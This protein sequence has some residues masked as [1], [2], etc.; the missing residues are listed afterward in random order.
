[1]VEHGIERFEHRAVRFARFRLRRGKPL[2][3]VVTEIVPVILRSAACCK[4]EAGKSPRPKFTGRL[5]CFTLGEVEAPAK[6]REEA[7]CGL[8]ARFRPRRA[9]YLPRSPAPK[10]RCSA[11]R[12]RRGFCPMH[13]REQ[14]AREEID[15][16]EKSRRKPHRETEGTA[17]R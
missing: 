8:G 11:R 7:G 1:M 2:V 4:T 16:G 14:I 5:L 15:E 9:R 3:Q 17:L 10:K 13:C 12:R 6:A